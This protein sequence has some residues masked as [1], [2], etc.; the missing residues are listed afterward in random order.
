MTK[1]VTATLWVDPLCPWAWLTSC[2][3]EQVKTVRDIT[4]TY[5]VMSLSVLNEG[6]DLPAEYQES[7]ARAWGPVRVLVNAAEQHGEAII[8]P[9]YRAIGERTH[10]GGSK[11]L[12]ANVAAALTELDL[13]EALLAVYDTTDV[14]DALRAS[15]H[16]AQNLVGDDVGTPVIQADGVAFFG[17]VVS[18]APVGEAA[19]KL[20]D[21]VLLVAQTP[22]FFELKRTRTVGPLF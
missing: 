15:H 3:L 9:L 16:R 12:R 13:P 18:P 8:A 19:G 22:E 11:D 1:T 7:M 5:Q 17:P 10:P 20:W 6:R 4:I 14:D 21:G 2:W